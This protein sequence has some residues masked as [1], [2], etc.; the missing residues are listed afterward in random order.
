MPADCTWQRICRKCRDTWSGL[1]QREGNHGIRHWV[2][3]GFWPMA[4]N[5]YLIW[6]RAV[7]HLN[8]YFYGHWISVF[9]FD[10]HQRWCL[11]RDC[12]SRECQ[13]ALCQIHV[14]DQASFLG[15]LCQRARPRRDT[16]PRSRLSA[17]PKE[18]RNLD[19]QQPRLNGGFKVE[20]W[21]ATH[22]VVK[23]WYGVLGV[24]PLWQSDHQNV[25]HVFTR[26]CVLVVHSAGWK[27]GMCW[28]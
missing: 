23:L 14:V 4:P 22:R 5:A 25:L 21:V 18:R 6:F 28:Y 20:F 2:P 1:L 24:V 10:Y 26:C 17:G 9:M 13:Q 3:L 19:G 12:H 7:L 8:F 16:Q 15:V 27:D 11:K